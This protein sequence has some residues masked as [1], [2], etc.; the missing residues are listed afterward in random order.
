M[1]GGLAKESDKDFSFVDSEVISNDVVNHNLPVST[2]LPLSS[3]EKTIKFILRSF[4]IVR[5]GE[6]IGIIAVAAKA[7]KIEPITLKPGT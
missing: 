5:H 4:C 6:N 1:Y 2:V 7:M 3:S